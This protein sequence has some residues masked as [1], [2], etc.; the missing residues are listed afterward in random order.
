MW[1]GDPFG[2]FT[3]SGFA[4]ADATRYIALRHTAI[5][6]RFDAALQCGD[7]GDMVPEIEAAIAADCTEERLWGHLMVALY[8]S[9]RSSDAVRAYDRARI[10]LESELGTFPGDG[11][12]TLYRKISDKSG[13]PAFQT[14]GRAA[15]RLP[16]AGPA[17]ADAVRRSGLRTG[18]HHRCAGRR[19]RGIGRL[20]PT[21]W[22]RRNRE[23]ALAQTVSAPAGHA[24]M[25][26]AWAAHPPGVRL[27]LM[28]TWIQLLR[29]LGDELARPPVAPCVVSHPRG[30]RTGS[31]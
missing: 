31:R 5:E 14:A 22:C 26:V 17:R 4:H 8:R 3:H 1:R 23:T 18:H 6:A 13:R 11:L 24:G 12:Q 21:D 2:E 9:G 16:R 20:D 29:R 28:W 19:T 7:G 27:P 30:R 25:A 10:A 15:E